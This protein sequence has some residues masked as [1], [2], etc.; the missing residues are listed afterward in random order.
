MTNNNEFIEFLY[1]EGK[2][3]QQEY[4]RLLREKQYLEK[5]I[6][7]TILYITHINNFLE[8]IGKDKIVIPTEGKK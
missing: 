8:S 2:K 3:K 6:A 5:H 1:K 4:S 7:R